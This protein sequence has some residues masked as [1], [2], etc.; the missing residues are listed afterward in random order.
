MLPQ[1]QITREE[2]AYFV[3]TDRFYFL[4]SQGKQKPKKG[5]K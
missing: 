5:R 2:D 1:S 4:S 3:K